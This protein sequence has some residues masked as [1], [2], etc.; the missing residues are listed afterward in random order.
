MKRYLLACLVA[1]SVVAV[2][3]GC[4]KDDTTSASTSSGLVGVWKASE[5]SG[6][7]E[8]VVDFN[9]KSAGSYTLYK[10][11]KV[12]GQLDPEQKVIETGNYKVEGAKLRLIPDGGQEV[13]LTYVL[14]G[15]SLELELWGRTW[16]FKEQ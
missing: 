15:K 7:T 5:V 14:D 1:F 4:G 13:S 8:T 11:V 9:L 10:T 2:M 3:S 12:D 6:N 16:K